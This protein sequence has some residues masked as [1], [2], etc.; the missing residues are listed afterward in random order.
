MSNYFDNQDKWFWNISEKEVLVTTDHGDHAHT[1]DI[2]NVPIGEI[3]WKT[4]IQKKIQ[5]KVLSQKI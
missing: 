2:M 1:L 5:L 3:I 4:R